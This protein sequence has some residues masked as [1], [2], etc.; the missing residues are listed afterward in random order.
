LIN[1]KAATAGGAGKATATNSKKVIDPVEDFV[2]MEY[3]SAG[4]ICAVVDFSLQSL[5]KVLQ[6][7]FRSIMST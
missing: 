2:T 6:L 1:R 5:K 3:E 7:R 4:E